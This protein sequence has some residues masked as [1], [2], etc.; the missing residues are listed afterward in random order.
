MEF[1][2]KNAL[3]S[4]VKMMAKI[5]KII[6]VLIVK[7]NGQEM[8]NVTMHVIMKDVNET[9]V[10]VKN[11]LQ[12]VLQDQQEIINVMKPVMQRNANEMEEIVKLLAK[13]NVNQVG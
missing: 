8:E 1:V 9:K 13:V 2:N 12:D 7:K 11:V 5:A 10:I 6:V 3:T 4:N